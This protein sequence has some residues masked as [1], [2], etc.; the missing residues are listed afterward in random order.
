MRRDKTKL[1]T[2]DNGHMQAHKGMIGATAARQMSV[3]AK[4]EM[5][6][7]QKLGRANLEAGNRNRKPNT[8][9]GK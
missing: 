5:G 7:V 1:F 4:K 3:S 9:V 6:P 2:A 8:K